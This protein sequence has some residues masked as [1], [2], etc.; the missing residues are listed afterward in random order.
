MVLLTD[1]QVTLV[2][3]EPGSQAQGSSK[4]LGIG[5]FASEA[6]AATGQGC[7]NAS[8]GNGTSENVLIS[9]AK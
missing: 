9:T 7:R 4:S 2:C 1:P 6:S 3:V 8:L 5:V